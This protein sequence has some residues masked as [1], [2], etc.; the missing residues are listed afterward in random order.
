MEVLLDHGRGSDARRLLEELAENTSAQDAI[1]AAILARRLR[2]PRIAHRYF[3]RAG[4]AVWA[5][6]R[7]LQEFAQTKMRLAQEA[8]GQQSGAWREVNRRL[9]VEARGLLERV[10]SMDASPT[11]HAWAW[12]ELART[13]NWL[14][15]PASEVES[16]FEN[17]VRLLPDE[18]RFAEELAQFRER[19]RE[20]SHRPA[21]NR[22]NGRQS[23]PR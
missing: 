1:D 10:I 3:Q 11:R 16:A 12:R 17:A 23:P 4:D 5:D 14:R 8:R 22:R 9:L 15:A 2:E 21:G 19:Q 7:A 18:P 6:P 20:R 13:L